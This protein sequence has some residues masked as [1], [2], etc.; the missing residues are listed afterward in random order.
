MTWLQSRRT[1]RVI[2]YRYAA[3]YDSCAALV[4]CDDILIIHSVWATHAKPF[5]LSFQ[6]PIP[7]NGLAVFS[8]MFNHSTHYQWYVKSDTDTDFDHPTLKHREQLTNILLMNHHS[9]KMIELSP[10]R[11]C[12]QEGIPKYSKLSVRFKI[13]PLNPIEQ[14]VKKSLELR[15]RT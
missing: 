6:H 7:T 2:G 15:K 12:A 13:S 14:I 3:Q 10:S 8:T 1:D 5:S 9:L 11:L 4:F